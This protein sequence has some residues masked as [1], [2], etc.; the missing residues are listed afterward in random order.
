LAG[1]QSL[2]RGNT[3]DLLSSNSALTSISANPSRFC[4]VVGGLE[5]DSGHTSV[6]PNFESMRESEDW[7]FSS[8]DAIEPSIVTA[9]KVH[10]EV[11]FSRW[12]ADETRYLTIPALWI[13]TRHGNHW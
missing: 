9:K 7:H 12:Y 3:F 4:P 13:A 1:H 2:F 6:R 10:L 11:V 5:P 8:F